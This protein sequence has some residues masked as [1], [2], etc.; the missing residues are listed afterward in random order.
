[1]TT[2]NDKI[3]ARRRYVAAAFA[4]MC[5]IPAASLGLLLYGVDPSP[6]A[7]IFATSAATFSALIIGN[8]ATTPKGT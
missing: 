8:F 7:G 4:M 5:I 6:A 1:M 2:L 3:Q